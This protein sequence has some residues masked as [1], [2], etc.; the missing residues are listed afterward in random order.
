[1]YVNSPIIA[2]I[3]KDTNQKLTIKVRLVETEILYLPAT[4]TRRLIGVDTN[5]VNDNLSI[6]EAFTTKTEQ[7]IVT[8]TS[9][10]LSLLDIIAGFKVF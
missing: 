10:Y 7:M 6:I 1:M 3:I 8:L 5:P 9:N 2:H 4:N